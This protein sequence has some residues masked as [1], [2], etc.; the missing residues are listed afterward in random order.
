MYVNRIITSLGGYVE[1]SHDC[2]LEQ[3]RVNPLTAGAAYIRVLIFY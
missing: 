2:E 3:R 1:K